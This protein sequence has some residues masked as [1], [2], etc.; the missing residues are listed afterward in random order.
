MMEGFAHKRQTF[1]AVFRIAV[2]LTRDRSP[3]TE[4]TARYLSEDAAV[5]FPLL[6]IYSGD[7]RFLCLALLGLVLFH[8]VSRCGDRALPGSG[9]PS[10]HC[11]FSQEHPEF[12]PRGKRLARPTSPLLYIVPCLGNGKRCVSYLPYHARDSRTL[13]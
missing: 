7:F 1:V 9:N 13:I 10:Y 11:T 5:C 12:L 2:T 4:A 6:D 8:P 3:Q